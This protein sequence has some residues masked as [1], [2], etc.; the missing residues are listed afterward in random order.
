MAEQRRFECP[1]CGESITAWS[2]GN[3][4]YL[5]ANGD[6]VYAYHPNHDELE[7]CIGNDSPHICLACAATFTVDSRDPRSECPSCGGTSFV[8][9][10]Q[11]EGEMCPWCHEGTI[12]KDPRIQAIS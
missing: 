3:P 1:E 7:R 6:K 9:V 8:P 5:D 2:D 12:V 10:F 11:L 4:Y